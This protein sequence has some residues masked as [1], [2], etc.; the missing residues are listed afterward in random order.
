MFTGKFTVRIVLWLLVLIFT[1]CASMST[2]QTARVTEKGKF[3][4]LVDG[5]F[6][7][8][9]TPQSPT[10]FL[11]S[12]RF[13]ELGVRYGV[14]DHL[15]AGLKIN[16]GF[17]MLLDLKYQLLGDK[18]SILAGSVGLGGSYMSFKFEDA[19]TRQY[20]ALLPFYF[21]Y[22][23]VDWISL[24]CSP[25]YIFEISNNYDFK[26][27]EGDI[28]FSHWY[29]ASGGIRIGKRIAFLAEYSL[30]GKNNGTAPFSQITCGLAFCFYK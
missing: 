7:H 3:D 4:Y 12:F 11:N 26:T 15:D 10:D 22:H 28:G 6:S 9:V 16:S 2:M 8:Y 29:G 18:N 14:S 30:F 17:T 19:R 27:N 1:G 24:Y 20:H 23:P 5:G 21:S 13:A 25:K